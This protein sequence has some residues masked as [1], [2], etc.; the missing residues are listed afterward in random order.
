ML[1]NS[2]RKEGNL[3]WQKNVRHHL[4]VD[5]NLLNWFWNW[6]EF[7]CFN[8]P[9]IDGYLN[10]LQ[11]NKIKLYAWSSASPP[12]CCSMWKG[13]FCVGKKIN[14]LS[15]ERSRQRNVQNELIQPGLLLVELKMAHIPMQ[16]I[17]KGGQIVHI[18]ANLF[19]HFVPT[20][21]LQ[22]NYPYKL[23]LSHVKILK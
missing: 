20:H 10:P 7:G 21:S 6:D 11:S 19:P 22:Q 12:K 15:V 13:N 5:E 2:K 8:N 4:L 14:G 23:M 3:N 17:Q 16:W 18:C 1:H 9:Q